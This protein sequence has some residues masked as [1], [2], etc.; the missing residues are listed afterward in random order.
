M[1]EYSLLPGQADAQLVSMLMLLQDIL[2]DDL[3][4]SSHQNGHGNG[5]AGSWR[6][7][8]KKAPTHV[9]GVVRCPPSVEV[10]TPSS[11][12]QEQGSSAGHQSPLYEAHVWTRI[13]EPA[14]S[15]LGGGSSWLGMR[16]IAHK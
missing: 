1:R 7:V 16:P 3:N 2:L 8:E 12:L 10:S 13:R 11:C 4:Q 15:G 5:A 6:D 14:L 9:V